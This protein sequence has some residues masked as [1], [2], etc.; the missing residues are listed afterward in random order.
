VTE[1]D[2]TQLALLGEAAE[3]VDGVA[4]FVWD[5]DRTYVAVNTAACELVGRT[6]EEILQ[7]RVGDMTP[8]RASPLFEQ[9]VHATGPQSGTHRFAGG[10]IRYLTTPTKIAGLPYW[11]SMC[12]REP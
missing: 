3:C 8:E 2:V 9:M 1:I 4:I 12:W 5:D 11:V 7:M 10:E 6:R